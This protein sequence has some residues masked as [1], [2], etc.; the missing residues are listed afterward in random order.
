MSP[1]LIRRFATF[2]LLTALTSAVTAAET[3]KLEVRNATGKIELTADDLRPIKFN[4]AGPVIT[5]FALLSDGKQVTFK[6]T[7]KEVP[8][9]GKGVLNIYFDTDNNAATGMQLSSPNPGGFEY[10]ASL[11]A[12][13]DYGSET[14]ICLGGSSGEPTRRWAGIKLKHFEGKS[15]NDGKT[16]IDP[17]GMN[18]WKASARVPITEKIVQGSIS[19]DDLKIKHGQTLR[20]LITKYSLFTHPEDFFPEIH[21]KL[22]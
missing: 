2:A 9:S 21:L 22:Q 15:E 8:N 12:C 11:Y 20:V 19:Y 4:E 7:L 16:T 14:S 17:L 6:A 10:A 13:A 18:G 1:R 5:T 3:G